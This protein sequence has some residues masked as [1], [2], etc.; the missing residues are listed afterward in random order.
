MTWKRIAV[1][2]CWL[3]LG[4]L[5]AFCMAQLIRAAWNDLWHAIFFIGFVACVAGPVIACELLDRGWWKR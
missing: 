2:V 3:P 4:S 1:I 5:T